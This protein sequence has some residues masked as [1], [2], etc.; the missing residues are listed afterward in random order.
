MAL[1]TG[2]RVAYST[3]GGVHL[4][5]A[6]Y[7]SS[8]YTLAEVQAFATGTPGWAGAATIAKAQLTS[9]DSEVELVGQ[10]YF[11]DAGTAKLRTPVT[12][13]AYKVA[14]RRVAARGLLKTQVLQ[15]GWGILD[16]LDNRR[17]DNAIGFFRKLLAVIALDT[18]L[19]SD[20]N[21]AILVA[22][23]RLDM[24]EWIHEHD[25]DTWTTHVGS[26]DNNWYRTDSTTN[27]Q[28]WTPVQVTGVTLGS[29]WAGKHIL[30]ELN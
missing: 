1:P 9:Y 10:E 29:G 6:A 13:S 28:L 30:Q 2:Y 19:S 14:E 12:T 5:R 4:V 26:T 15:P 25:R 22:E 16:K 20:T 7:K 24:I 27:P 8:A 21:Y 18:V 11:D 3:V 23:L 17:T